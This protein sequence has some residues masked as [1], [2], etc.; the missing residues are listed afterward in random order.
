MHVFRPS[1]AECDGPGLQPWSGPRTAWLRLRVML[2][3]QGPLCS[4]SR[5]QTIITS[6]TVLCHQSALNK[7]KS[8]QTIIRP[9]LEDARCTSL[10]IEAQINL[11]IGLLA[12]YKLFVGGENPIE[13]SIKRHYLYLQ[14]SHIGNCKRYL[15][16]IH[17]KDCM[18][19]SPI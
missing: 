8:I 1:W 4:P 16:C 2:H 14:P 3:H 7:E 6:C 9:R 15:I 17:L 12:A 13:I 11:N 5:T 18:A 10:D 19:A